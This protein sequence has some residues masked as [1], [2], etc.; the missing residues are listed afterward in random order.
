M[1]SEYFG[2]LIIRISHLF[3]ISTFVLRVLLLK[4]FHKTFYSTSEGQRPQNF[5]FIITILRK[6]TTHFLLWIRPSSAYLIMF[7]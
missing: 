1:V 3:R 5:N 7:Y 2:F 6:Y 4:I